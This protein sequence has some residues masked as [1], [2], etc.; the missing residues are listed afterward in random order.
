MVEAVNSSDSVNPSNYITQEKLILWLT[1]PLSAFIILSNLFI[2]IGI[3][4]NKKL[5]NTANYF[6]LSLLFA[7]FFTGVFLPCMP[8]MRFDK[9][10][11]Y[12][13]CL[14][15]FISPNY[16]FLSFLAN[17]LMV[18]YEKYL[19]IIYPLHYRNF[20]VHRCVPF[21]LVMVWT[22]PLLFASLPILG[23][24]N[25]NSSLSCSYKQVFPHAYIYLETY[26]LVIPSILAMSFIT[27]KLLS[28]A[29]R[30]LKEIKKLHRSVQREAATELEHQ[31]DLRYAKCIAIFSLTFLICW[32]P[33]I[34]LLQV[35]VL[36]IENYDIS[37]SILPTLTCLGSGSATIVPVILGLCHHQYTELWRTLCKRYCK[38]CCKPKVKQPNEHNMVS[39]EETL[40]D[41]LTGVT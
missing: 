34:A 4:F 28:V 27:V 11:G 26:G 31:M 10:L 14:L 35:S 32:V 1:N 8:R 29:R 9:N 23:W 40:E 6:F 38:F 18:H 12:H 15:A 22:L 13:W 30:Q 17:L 41:G 7:D 19:C 39:K 2:I 5:H 24:N 33:Y 3:V 20:L 36:A 37:F 16:F 25:W 21:F